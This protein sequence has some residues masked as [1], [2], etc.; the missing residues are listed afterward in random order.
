[1][2]IDYLCGLT[3]RRLAAACLLL[4]C[5]GGF[6]L[7]RRRDT[8]TPEL[9]SQRIKQNI[10]PEPGNVTLAIVA[11][12]VKGEDVQWMHDLRPDW[13]PYIYTAS[14]PPEPDY[15]LA[16]PGY[17]GREAVVYLDFIIRYY[18]NLPG[19]TAFVHGGKTQ[20]HNVPFGQKTDNIW[21]Q[22]IWG[23]TDKILQSLRLDSVRRFGYLNLRCQQDP[24]CPLAVSPFEPTETDIMNQ[25]VRAYFLDVYMELFQV[26]REEV[27]KE[28][29]GICCAQF[30]VT[31]EKI[32]ERPKSDYERMLGW[33]L[34]TN[35]T[36]AFGVG[37][38]F[39]TIWHRIFNMEAVHCP[40]VEECHCNLFGLCG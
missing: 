9:L 5:I 10:V 21:G 3:R 29:G 39:E 25:D 33:A 30:A 27:P 37:W 1:M 36:D 8:L 14:E 4:L 38:V 24:G 32:Q 35:V 23:R 20:W 11:P 26:S 6:L 34:T 31:R 19:I 13:I 2:R 18:D 7:Q 40:M 28:V 16:T 15:H 17:Q 12:K 22:Q